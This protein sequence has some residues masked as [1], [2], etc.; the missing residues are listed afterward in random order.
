[1]MIGGSLEASAGHFAVMQHASFPGNQYKA[2]RMK[3]LY[4]LTVKSLIS[5]RSYLTAVP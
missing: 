5:C 2:H 1:M 4:V 3:S